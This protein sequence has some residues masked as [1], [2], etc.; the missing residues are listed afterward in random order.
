MASKTDS[1]LPFVVAELVRR[2]TPEEK[3][4]FLRYLP[5]EELEGLAGQLRGEVGD[6]K[7]L[8]KTRSDGLS[9]EM[10]PSRMVDFISRLPGILSTERIDARYRQDGNRR[11]KS[12][13]P[14][15]F[16]RLLE[17]IESI[18]AD[19]P[20][21][22][23]F[24]QHTLFSNGGGCMLLEADLSNDVKREIGETFLKVCGFPR[25]LSKDQ[26]AISVWGDGEE[27]KED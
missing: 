14:H 4:Q 18:L 8:V 17:E 9:F 23:E 3:A 20:V 26:F 22:I 10:P 16:S 21:V 5:L 1:N 13:S 11:E 24:D 12:C 19:D 27:V 2:M 6:P 7:V 15:E 25:R